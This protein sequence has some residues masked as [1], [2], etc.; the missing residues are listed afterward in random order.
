MAVGAEMPVSI[1]HSDLLWLHLVCVGVVGLLCLGGMY[2]GGYGCEGF[3]LSGE[4]PLELHY[5]R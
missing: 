4:R 1:A 2:I 3:A 5:Q